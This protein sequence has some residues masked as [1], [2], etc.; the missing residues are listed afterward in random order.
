MPLRLTAYDVIK[1]LGDMETN[2]TWDLTFKA[3]AAAVLVAGI[4]ACKGPVVTPGEVPA[5]PAASEVAAPLETPAQ[6]QAPPPFS[7]QYPLRR[8]FVCLPEH[9]AITAAHRGVSKG[10]GL[11]ENSAGSLKALIEKGYL[12]AEV[13]IAGLKDGVHIL[14]H[15]GVWDEKSTGKGPVASSAWGD[16]EKILLNDTDGELTAE[17]PVSLEAALALSKDRLYLE[18]DFKSSAKYE[19]VIT[20]IRAAG[21]SDRVILI[22]YNEAQARRMAMLAPEM[23]LS[24]TLRS[25]ADITALEN[26][27]IAKSNMN[28]WMGRGPYDSEFMAGLKSQSIP[29]L[30]WPQKEDVAVAAVP[31]SLIVTDYAYQHAPIIGLKDEDR[32]AYQSCLEAK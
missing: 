18:I 2:M 20:A 21:M 16:A 11:A 3:A 7:A 17:R 9:A 28:A 25:D 10:E 15:D 32:A 5:G 4:A 1:A 27:G 12:V 26:E 13:D 30:A 24:V 22:A 23:L 19:T 14:Y 6:V 8:Q 31:A 29:V